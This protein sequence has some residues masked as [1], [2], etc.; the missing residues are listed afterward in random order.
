MCIDLL[1]Y[2]F[3]ID[4]RQRYLGHGMCLIGSNFYNEK[5]I[6]KGDSLKFVL[7]GGLDL[8]FRDSIVE[9]TVTFDTNKFQHLSDV[10]YDN[11]ES[12]ITVTTESINKQKLRMNKQCV[13]QAKR[14]FHQFGF[15]CILNCKNE[16]VIAII[17]SWEGRDQPRRDIY[18]FNCITYELTAKKNVC[19][20]YILVFVF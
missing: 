16:P 2:L 4:E 14:L 1:I 17:G 19:N 9:V 13:N 15:E 20:F 12:I 3:V 18:L 11:F 5:D 7:F 6:S 8:R 10:N